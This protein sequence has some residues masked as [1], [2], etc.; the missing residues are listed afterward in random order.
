[1][2]GKSTYLRQQAIICLLAHCGIF[3]PCSYV[4]IEIVDQ[5]FSRISTNDDLSKG[6]STFTVET[7]EISLT[8]N[9]AINKSFLILDEVG[10]GTSVEEGIALADAILYCLL[11]Q[12]NTRTLF[13]TH[14]Y[15]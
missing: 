2:A 6:S 13:A 5:I 1:M 10:R 4:K 15:P 9:R 11:D 14:F 7:I 8:L 3:V 12:L